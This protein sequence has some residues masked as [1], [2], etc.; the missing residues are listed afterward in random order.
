MAGRV[1]ESV[2]FA[3]LGVAVVE[4]V[5]IYKDTAPSLQ[6]LR[7]APP[8]DFM[9]RQLVLDADLMGLIVV[10]ALGGGGTMLVR[11]WYPL[12]LACAALLLVS[13]Y[14]R[15]VLNSSNQGMMSND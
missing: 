9:S 6:E 15:S 3:A 14:Y 8:G 7:C 4:T 5:K 1:D 12:L 13:G 10:V 2:A 11:K